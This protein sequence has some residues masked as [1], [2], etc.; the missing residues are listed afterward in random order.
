M[1][2]CLSQQNIDS[3]AL[4][5]EIDASSEVVR[6]SEN[7]HVQN[8]VG[9]APAQVERSKYVGGN[10]NGMAHQNTVE[11]T[12]L[13]S[14]KA[15][16]PL[17]LVSPDDQYDH[18]NGFLVPMRNT[19]NPDVNDPVYQQTFEEQRIVDQT[20][21][22]QS[23]HE[24]PVHPVSSYPQSSV[25]QLG[26]YMRNDMAHQNA[27]KLTLLSSNQAKQPYD[28][29]L[30]DVHHDHQN[31]NEPVFNTPMGNTVT[32]YVDQPVYEQTFA[33]K[34]MV[35]QTVNKQI[36]DE[37]PVLRVSS[38]GHTVLPSQSSTELASVE[39]TENV[40][41]GETQQGGHNGLGVF[42]EGRTYGRKVFDPILKQYVYLEENKFHPGGG[43]LM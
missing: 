36:F 25:K 7:D 23:F 30:S 37:Q 5:A 20:L 26:A 41:I 42:F 24:Q 16:Q 10:W 18:Q 34:P 43:L 2:V 31:R 14:N 15:K 8:N 35:A 39:V 32:T 29:V 12:L 21:N 33:K 40:L 22:N 38:H 19:V 1:G 17:H 13:S 11:P 6:S 27:S 28:F 9:Q 3:E 4:K